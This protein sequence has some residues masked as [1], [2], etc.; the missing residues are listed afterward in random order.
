MRVSRACCRASRA[1]NESI[2]DQFTRQAKPFAAAA[3]IV[4]EDALRLTMRACAVAPND[5]VLD[6]ACGPGVLATGLA[7]EARRVHGID[8][9]PAMLER[10]RALARERGVDER[11][12]WDLGDATKLPYASG[13]FSLVSARLCFH[14][15][16]DPLVVVHEMV[17]VCAP[18]GRVMVIDV[19]P[20]PAVA[21]AFNAAEKL[22]DPSHVRALPLDEHLELFRVAGLPP[23]SVNTYQLRSDVDA[24]LK[25]SFPATPADAAAVRAMFVRSAQG[26]DFLGIG[27]KFDGS[28]VTYGFPVS[29]MVSQRV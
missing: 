15:F 4:D 7:R 19:T 16:E 25:R 17:R 23:P 2:V 8:I 11:C 27:A 26:D 10:A 3:P 6:V 24:L 13:A 5:T 28:L 12:S 20:T 21:V 9:T 18:T 1:H 22:R 14:H 29:I